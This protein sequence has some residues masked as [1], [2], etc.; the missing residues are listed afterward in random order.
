MG[1]QTMALVPTQPP[2]VFCKQSFFGINIH[3][4]LHIFY[5]VKLPVAELTR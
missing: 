5:V 3:Q 1:Q 2:L 4:C